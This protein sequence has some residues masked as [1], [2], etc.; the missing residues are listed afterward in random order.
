M[1]DPRFPISPTSVP[2]TSSADGVGTGKLRTGQA[3]VSRLA[4]LFTREPEL[5]LACLESSP[6]DAAEFEESVLAA[7]EEAVKASPKYADLHYFA[8]R[9]AA[10]LSCTERAQALVASAIRINPSYRDALILAA[11]LAMSREQEDEALQYL[12]QALMHGAD[13]ADVHLM[14]GDIWSQREELGL[15]REEYARAIDLNAYFAAARERIA[16]LSPGG[17]EGGGHGLPS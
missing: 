11:R 15:A 2:Q 10:T 5:I 9:A 12:R 7:A 6:E 14:L 8:A 13:Y 17:M 4:K 1:T 3:G 16:A